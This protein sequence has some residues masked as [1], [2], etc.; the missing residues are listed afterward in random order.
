MAKQNA[1]QA[2]AFIIVQKTKYTVYVMSITI[3]LF[4][5]RHTVQNENNKSIAFLL[6]LYKS[7]N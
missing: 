6:C 1:A 5:K 7:S 4:L 2:L 3:W